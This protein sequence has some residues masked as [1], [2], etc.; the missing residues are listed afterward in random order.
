MG[1]LWERTSIHWR[2]S[3]RPRPRNMMNPAWPKR[4]ASGHL[5]HHSKMAENGPLREH[6]S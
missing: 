1:G 5:E 3:Q 4:I 2:S 6:S